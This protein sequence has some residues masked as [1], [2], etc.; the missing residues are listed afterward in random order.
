MDIVQAEEL[1][2][3]RMASKNWAKSTCEN[4]ASQVRVFLRAFETRDRARNITANEIEQYLNSNA[5]IN[6]RK[7][8]RCAI[9]LPRIALN[10]A[11]I[12]G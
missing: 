12:L 1:F 10:K 4:Y 3:Q 8:A 9:V 7:H 5:V 2:V 11:L 6:S